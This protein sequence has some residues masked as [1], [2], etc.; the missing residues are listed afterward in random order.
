MSSVLARRREIAKT[1]RDAL[2]GD[3]VALKWP[4]RA[5]G[6]GCVYVTGSF[7]RNE[8][9][10]HSDLDLFIVGKGAEQPLLSRLDQI[11]LKADLIA[12]TRKER[13]PNGWRFPELDS[14]G[15]YLKHHTIH[16]LTSKLGTPE[17]DS[18]NTLTAR[19]LLLLESKVLFGE[20]VYA[21]AID[22]VIE[23]YW[24]DYERHRDDFMPAFLAND[25]LR[26]WR[27]F[28]LNYEAR[29]RSD[30]PDK[31]AK[32]KLK[33]YKLKHSR[34]LTCFSALAHL[35]LYHKR[36]NTVTRDDVK[37]IVSLTPTERL[38]AIRAEG[39]DTVQSRVDSV[40]SCYEDFLTVTDRSEADLLADLL[41]PERSSE[42]MSGAGR[43]GDRF[44]DLLRELGGDSPFFR[45]MLV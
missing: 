5:A 39:N 29:T 23:K 45:F 20:D 42:L 30:P 11:C 22:Q 28:C 2:V 17:D 24:V 15:E 35:L 19:L 8:A 44:Y 18:E 34:L 6:K 13:A 4:E 12:S 40:I 41:N 36:A 14:D 27:T 37:L 1:R 25:I 32:R 21:D 9:S 38:E 26:L 3:L 7:G 43:L 31:K 33:N 10:E 16:K